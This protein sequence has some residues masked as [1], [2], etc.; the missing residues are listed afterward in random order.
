VA[1]NNSIKVGPL[2]FLLYIC[3]YGEYYE[4]A[5][6][7]MYIYIYIYIYM[8]HCF[9]TVELCNY[10]IIYLHITETCSR[11][12]FAVLKAYRRV[13]F[14]ILFILYAQQGCHP[15]SMNCIS[16][17]NILTWIISVFA[18]KCNWLLK[19]RWHLYSTSS[20]T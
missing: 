11:C 10:D 18:V 2:V 9:G 14:L 17:L 15:L 6:I 5:C 13:T 4:T 20:E 12:V 3:N 16:V 19:S 8:I 7:Y 1:V